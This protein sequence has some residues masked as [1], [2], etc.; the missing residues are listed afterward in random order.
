MTARNLS[1]EGVTANASDVLQCDVRPSAL[2]AFLDAH[3]E[4]ANRVGKF[5]FAH[6]LIRQPR[7]E[8]M[9]LP[10]TAAKFD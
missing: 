5:G 4:I 2:S 1:P 6:A 8:E 7:A 3:H 10:L 9:G